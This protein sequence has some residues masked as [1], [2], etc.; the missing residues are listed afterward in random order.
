[1]EILVS[2]SIVLYK[3]D[4]SV[5]KTISD[6]LRASLP[7][8]LFLV[9]NSPTDALKC[10]LSDLINNNRVEYISNSKNL[11]FGAAHNIAIRKILNT[12]RYHLV[13][14]PDVFFFS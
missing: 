14:N 11:G 1:V 8:R 5:R 13:L 7:V 2:G 10:D 12:S 3:S 6:F 4:T 9:D